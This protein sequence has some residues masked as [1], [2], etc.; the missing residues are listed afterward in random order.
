MIIKFDNSLIEEIGVNGA[1]CLFALYKIQNQNNVRCG[2][3][4]E[5]KREQMEEITKINI[6][7]QSRILN[8]LAEK[9]YIEKLRK[10]IL[11]KKH[12]RILLD[13]GTLLYL[14]ND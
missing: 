2:E 14:F 12:Y 7:T 1:I 11:P 13:Y 6:R 3:W 4:F 8:K 9:G 5:C 10:G